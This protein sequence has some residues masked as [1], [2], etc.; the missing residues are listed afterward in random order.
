MGEKPETVSHRVGAAV[1]LGI[2]WAATA[3]VVIALI[4]LGRSIL[5]RWL[6]SDRIEPSILAELIATGHRIGAENPTV[7]VVLYTDYSCGFCREFHDTMQ[8]LLERY[9]QH[10]SFLVKLFVNPA[11]ESAYRVALG[12]ECA[13]AQ[14]QFEEYHHAAFSQPRLIG[15]SDGWKTLARSSGVSDLQK[16]DNC[17]AARVYDERLRRQQEEGAN[18]GVSAVPTL[19][20]DG[21][22]IVGAVPLDELDAIIASAFPE[23]GETPE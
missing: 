7:L 12:A 6:P 10:L 2:D 11:G 13:A 20:I 23:R 8:Q 3:I 14:S 15:Y 21:Q 18:V 16:F 22:P 1:K 17:V 4:A 9:P 5:S 19:I